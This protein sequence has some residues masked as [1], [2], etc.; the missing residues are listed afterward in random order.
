M[1]N[2]DGLERVDVMVKKKRGGGEGERFYS[3]GDKG[4]EKFYNVRYL[5]FL[6]NIT[7]STM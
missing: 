5:Y 6:T 7:R 3:R 4:H 2:E 1:F